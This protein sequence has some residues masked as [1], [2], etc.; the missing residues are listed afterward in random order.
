MPRRWVTGAIARARARYNMPLTE[1]VKRDRLEH[2]RQVQQAS[3]SARAEAV[4]A[5]DYG[6]LRRREAGETAQQIADTVGLT[7][8]AV[9]YGIRCAR[10]RRDE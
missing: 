4:R 8:S 7:P 3:A 1:A 2:A 10:K 6:F 9:A 5:R